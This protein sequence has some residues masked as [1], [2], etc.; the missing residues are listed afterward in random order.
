MSMKN[1]P[2]VEYLRE[3][4]EYNPE[5]GELIWK[6]RP[7]WH[8]KDIRACNSWNNKNSGKAAAS[9]GINKNGK[10]YLS[11]GVSG[12]IYRAHRVIFKLHYQSEP[13]QIDH[14]DGNGLNNAINNLRSVNQVGNARNHRKPSNNTSGHVGVYWD[15]KSK[16]Y[17]ASIRVMGKSHN[18]GFYPSLEEAALARRKAN[19][20]FGFHAGH[21]SDR[22]L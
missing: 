10:K 18:L 6:K 19:V 11:V 15:A 14:I 16:K 3:C 17:R 9:L 12:K 20:Q 22:P 21:G 7:R 4:F 5:S 2:S 8:F 13:Q 1:L